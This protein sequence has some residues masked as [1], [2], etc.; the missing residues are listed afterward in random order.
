MR[1]LT[2]SAVEES[3][4]R[5]CLAA[6][7]E[8][9]ADVL[10]AL[11]AAK[12]AEVPGSAAASVLDQLIENQRLARERRRPVCQDT[13]LV[14]VFLDVGRELFLQ[15]DVEA[16]V[17]AGVRRAYTEGYLR[18]SIL[19]PLSR[20]NTGDNTPAVLHV[21]YVPGDRLHVSVLP[22]GFG[23]ENQ[24]RL[25]M[26]T[27]AE[28]EEGVIRSIV[29]A[30]VEAGASACPPFVVGAGIGGT[31]DSAMLLAKRQL[32]RPVGAPAEDETLA[33]VERAALTRIN[34]SGIGP[35]GL[36][37]R[38]TALAVHAGAEPTHIAGL[39][40]AVSLQCH[41]CRR[42]GEVL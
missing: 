8:L 13:G 18:K 27:P 6:C 15:G 1:I 10:A 36:G 40:V 9:P 26:L 16:A 12:K 38:T 31:A 21:R 11:E 17:N 33:A 5:L 25:F 4:R 32:L 39:P 23:S 41:A 14:L 19:S 35:M 7:C 3:V 24:S 30:A 2:V 42:A 20:V 29:S 22:K 28:G 34:A 37:G